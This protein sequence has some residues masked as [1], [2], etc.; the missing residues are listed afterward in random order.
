M[1]FPS[2]GLSLVDGKNARLRG[3]VTLAV[4]GKDHQ[5]LGN[6]GGNPKAEAVPTTVGCGELLAQ[7]FGVRAFDIMAGHRS[8][9]QGPTEESHG[10]LRPF[11]PKR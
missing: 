7:F 11:L 4:I 10:F 1:E 6:R 8:R 9:Q 5:I 2:R 3:A